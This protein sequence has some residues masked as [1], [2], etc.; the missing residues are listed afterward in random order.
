MENKIII[1]G[2]KMNT[3]RI[4][5]VGANGT[6]AADTYS[7]CCNGGWLPWAQD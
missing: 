2:N 7:G 4:T 6:D 1:G 5:A 3:Y